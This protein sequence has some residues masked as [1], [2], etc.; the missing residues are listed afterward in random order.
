M[1]TRLHSQEL[2]EANEGF[3][4]FVDFERT[5]A[6]REALLE[7]DVI[8]Y[9]LMSNSFQEVDYVIKTLKT[10][11]LTSQ[12]TLVLLSSVMTW[13]NTPP[14][15]MEDPVEVGEDDEPVEEAEEEGEPSEDSSDQG[16]E[17]E[18]A[19]EEEEEG[20]KPKKL[21]IKYFK[22]TDFHLRVPHKDFEYLKTLETI[23]MS[24]TTTQPKLKVHVM[25]SGIRYGNGER[26]FYDHFQK[27]WIQCPAKLP[28][29]GDGRNRVPTI[30]IIDL[31]RIVKR[32]V[33][34]E[35]AQ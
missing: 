5:A 15:L 25:C 16:K 6:F 13:V 33:S 24:S 30:H 22:E 18:E 14:K 27:A 8:V 1:T 20:D 31:A 26:I 17:E 23:A 35:S 10:S 3:E 9:D 19:P 21:P 34:Q 2:Q 7:C 4:K 12:K 32:V 28:V 29:L 11:P